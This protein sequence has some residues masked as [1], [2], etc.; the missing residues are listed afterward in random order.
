MDKDEDSVILVHWLERKV[1]VHHELDISYGKGT[2]KVSA[3][4]I[5]KHITANSVVL[6]T[7]ILKMPVVRIHGYTCLRHTT[8]HEITSGCQ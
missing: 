3:L 8:E 5:S 2:R 1:E 4:V 7:A 6:W